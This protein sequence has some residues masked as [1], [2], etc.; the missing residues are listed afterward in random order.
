MLMLWYDWPLDRLMILLVGAAFIPMAVQAW[1]LHGRQNF[2]RAAMWTPVAGGLITGIAAM[3]LAIF[4]LPWL[5]SATALL[6]ALAALSGLIGFYYHLR[7]V[8]LRVDGY[9]LNNFLVGPPIILPLLLT[10]L[11]IFGLFAVYWR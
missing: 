9:A 8:G 6:F 11:G 10:V 1:L 3:L 2:R 4:N 7:G 5:L